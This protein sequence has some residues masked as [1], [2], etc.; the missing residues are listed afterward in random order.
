[1]PAAAPRSGAALIQIRHNSAARSW[2]WSWCWVVML[3]AECAWVL[4][5]QPGRRGRCVCGVRCPGVG[6]SGVWPTA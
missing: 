1:V 3:R 2:C 4:P 6:S 5:W